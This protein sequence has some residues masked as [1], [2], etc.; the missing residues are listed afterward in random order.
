MDSEL[1]GDGPTRRYTPRL[2]VQFP[3]C[4]QTALH[5]EVR[6]IARNHSPPRPLYPQVDYLFCCL[7][8]HSQNYGVAVPGLEDI[9]EEDIIPAFML[10][11][12]FT[13]V[14]PLDPNFPR[15]TVPAYLTPS[16]WTH[17]GGFLQKKGCYPER[18]SA[19]FKLFDFGRGKSEGL[20]D[21]KLT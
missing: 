21:Q 16:V 12:E 18:S 15:D 1:H 13:P 2:L 5:T 20:K 9:D 4:T 3:F 8:L 7:D 14:I 10:E 17:F 6:I 11:N 19:T